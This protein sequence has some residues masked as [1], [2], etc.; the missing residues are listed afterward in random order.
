LNQSGIKQKRRKIMG[1]AV[2]EGV[3]LK[4]ILAISMIALTGVMLGTFL[5]T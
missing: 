1:L 2:K 5:N 3:D 4:N